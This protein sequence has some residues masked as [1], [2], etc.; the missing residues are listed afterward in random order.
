MILLLEMNLII[1][2]NKSNKIII[3]IK[4]VIL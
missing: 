2:S 1:N 4:V 3:F